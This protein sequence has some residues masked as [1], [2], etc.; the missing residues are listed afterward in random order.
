MKHHPI[1]G[2]ANPLASFAGSLSERRV[3]ERFGKW[4]G[5]AAAPAEE[6]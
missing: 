3:Q 4:L 6:G 5:D 1:T 2:L